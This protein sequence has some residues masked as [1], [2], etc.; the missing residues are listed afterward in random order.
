[1]KTHLSCEHVHDVERE[2]ID[3]I[4]A[5]FVLL[6]KNL[7]SNSRLTQLCQAA[8]ISTSGLEFFHLIVLNYRPKR[9]H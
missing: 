2:S 5:A 6:L 7:S 4:S 9:Y 8:Y 3:T 1:M